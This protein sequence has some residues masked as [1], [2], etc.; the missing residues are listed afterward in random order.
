MTV[1]GRASRVAEEVRLD[2]CRRLEIPVFR[3]TTGGAAVMIGPGC[4]VYSVVLSY[5]RRR[6][7]RGIAQAHDFVIGTL[8]RAFDALAP[9]VQRHGICDLTISD[10]KFS[11]NSMRSCRDHLLYHGTVLYRFPIAQIERCLTMPPRVPKYRRGRTHESFLTNL[12]AGA[13]E[14]R[15]SI[16]RA[17]SAEEETR[18]WPEALTQQLVRSKYSRTDWNLRR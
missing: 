3:R 2:E 6:H 16:V 13:N 4:L 7:L 11:G 15:Q 12:R 5:E 9:G 8:C 10:L 17:W 1:V 14:I 18:E